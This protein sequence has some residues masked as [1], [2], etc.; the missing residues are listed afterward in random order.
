MVFVFDSSD[1]LAFE[2]CSPKTIVAKNMLNLVLVSV[3]C[4]FQQRVH[5]YWNCENALNGP[6]AETAMNNFSSTSFIQL[7]YLHG[8]EPHRP[9]L[10]ESGERLLRN[11][12][13]SIRAALLLFQVCHH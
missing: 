8:L 11:Y 4:S 12:Q 13:Y 9:G 1:S 7:Q 6:S 5:H 10:L 3:G 2:A